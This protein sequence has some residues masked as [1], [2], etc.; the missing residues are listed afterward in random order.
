MWKYPTWV[1]FASMSS[2]DGPSF[3]A[4]AGGTLPFMVGA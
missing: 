2:E 3:Y 1:L 4:S